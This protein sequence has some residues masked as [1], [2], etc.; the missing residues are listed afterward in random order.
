[1][2]PNNGGRLAL[3]TSMLAL[4]VASAGTGYAA[5]TIGTADLKKNAVTSPKVKNDALTGKDVKESSLATVPS[6]TTATTATNAG[7]AASVGGINVTEVNYRASATGASAVV[8]AGSG[9]TIT[10]TCAGFNQIS[11]VAHTTQVASFITAFASSDGGPDV[12]S[13][14]QNSSFDPGDAFDLLVGT[15]GNVT[16]TE[17]DFSAANGSTVAGEIIADEGLP[18]C[19]ATG[20]VLSG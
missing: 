4:V 12:T 15:S 2:A 6:A 9:L 16:R 18:D 3:A 19:L 20:M 8:F 17:F 14:T 1:M 7:N 13:T 11:L 5:G 10:A